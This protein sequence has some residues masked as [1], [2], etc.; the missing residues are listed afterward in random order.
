V[1]ERR[2]PFGH[3]PCRP[4]RAI[5]VATVFFDTRQ[6][7]A[8]RVLPHPRRPV[9]SRVATRV[10][11]GRLHRRVQLGPAA[12][13]GGRFTVVP[14]VEPRLADWASPLIVEGPVM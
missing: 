9:G 14:L 1:S 13:A 8:T 2:L 6:P 5:D 4:W 10:V 12:L 11:E 7:A 3:R